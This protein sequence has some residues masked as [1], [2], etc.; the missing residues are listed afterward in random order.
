[1]AYA[2]AGG[3]GKGDIGR[4]E[5]FLLNYLSSLKSFP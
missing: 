5:R 4:C 1:V 2:D 3:R